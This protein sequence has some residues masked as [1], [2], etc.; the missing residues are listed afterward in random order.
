MQRSPA[1]SSR[2]G[3]LLLGAAAAGLLWGGSATALPVLGSAAPQVSAGGAQPVISSSGST[4]RVD[5]NAART[6]LDWS[7]FNLGPGERAD[8]L[9]DQRNWIAVNRVTGSQISINGQVFAGQA[10]N[11]NSPAPSGPGGN[12]WF[13]SPQG[14][15]FGP[16]ARVDV[17]GLVATSS[18]PNATA[19]LNAGNVNIPFAGSGAGGPVTVASG[20]Q[21]NATAAVALV[22]PRV[23]TAAGS[24]V[25]VS[26]YGAALYGGADSFEIQFFPTFNN[27]LTLFTFIVP[28]R[29]AGTPNPL[30]LNIAGQTTSGTIYLAA[31]S[32]AAVASELINAP[33]LLTARSS[34]REYGQVT[35]TT[36]RNII[37]GQPGENGQ[38]QHQVTGV[39]TGNVRVGEINADGNVNVILT[40]ADVGASGVLLGNLD[41]A[42]IRSG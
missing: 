9:F 40:P 8:F 24:T 34:F 36:G 17:G 42:K 39:T 41:A 31:Y 33:G 22:A 32:R 14:V 27:D 29:A 21:L 6:I 38:T 28:N 10:A 3:P 19:F 23:S 26:D 20:A 35:I 16:N 13:Y 7:S 18:A 30:A 5:L 15:A 25:T 11:L 12:V 1:R 37:L 4:V 2:R